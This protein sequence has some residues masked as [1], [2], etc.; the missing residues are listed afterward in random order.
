VDVYDSELDD[1]EHEEEE[2]NIEYRVPPRGFEFSEEVPQLD[3]TFLKGE[4]MYK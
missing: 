3:R 1:Y 2:E 4:I